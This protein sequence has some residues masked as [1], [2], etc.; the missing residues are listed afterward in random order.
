[1]KNLGDRM[2]GYEQSYDTS[3]MSR[4]PIIVRV[5]GKSFS[6]WT[7]KINAKKPFDLPLS[8]M[9]VEAMRYTASNI[10]G[11]VFGYTQSDEMT[12]VIR[13]DQSLESTPWFGNRVQKICSVVSSM[14]TASFNLENV[15]YN[16]VN[17]IA[18]FD[19]RVFA[20]PDVQEAINCLIWRQ[21]D[22]VKNSIS[23]SCYYEVAEKIGKKTA[24][25]LMHGLNQ[26]KQQELLFQQTGINW[27]DYPVKFKRGVG[28]YRITYDTVIDGNECVRSKWKVDEEI[29]IFTRDTEFLYN[30]FKVGD[31]DE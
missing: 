18:H 8:E 16:G 19:A 5:D 2:K 22:A 4:V 24:R 9:M 30:L 11:C 20:V 13:N 23:A 12:F 1:M 10:E 15:R 7:K 6:K 29:P 31:Q 27:N 14:V 17:N 21:N 25:K 26:N 28:T 3:I